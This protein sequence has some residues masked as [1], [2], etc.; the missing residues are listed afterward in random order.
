[1][2]IELTEEHKEENWAQVQ[3]F[4]SSC[5]FDF[6]SLSSLGFSS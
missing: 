4:E 1:M 6:L 3:F 5:F 2:A